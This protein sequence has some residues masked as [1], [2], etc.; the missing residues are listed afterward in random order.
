MNSVNL[1]TIIIF[2][3]YIILFLFITRYIIYN[4]GSLKEYYGNYDNYN[5]YDFRLG[6]LQPGSKRLMSYDIRGDP[7]IYPQYIG[8]WN[9]A[10][11]VPLYNP[12]LDI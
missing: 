9:N 12:Q 3:I 2:I 5:Y 7:P 1:K 8:P 4:F 6:M 10:S 11:V